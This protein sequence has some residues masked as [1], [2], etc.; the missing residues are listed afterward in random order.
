MIYFTITLS[1][2]FI[3]LVTAGDPIVEISQG[4]LVGKAV[5]F[6]HKDVD[7][8]RTVHVFK[9]IPYAEPPIGDL[10]FRP[11]K[12]KAAWDGVYDATYFRSIC[13]Q[14]A[15]PLFPVNGQQD[16]DCLFL[17]VYAPQLTSAKLP[18]MLFL[19]GGVFIVG[20]GTY[21]YE[22]TAL[23]AIGDVIVVCINYRLGPFGFFTTGDDNAAGNYAFYD[24]IAALQWVQENIEAFGG[25]PSKVT[26]LGESAGSI[27]SEYLMMSP[28]TEGLFQRIIMQSATSTFVGFHG[29]AG[30][31]HHKM[32]HGLGKLLGCDRETSEELVQCL[33]TVPAEDFR[34]AT[35]PTLGLLAQFIGYGTPFPPVVDGTLVTV[36]PVDFIR[37]KMLKKRNLDIMI[38]S[39]AD[40]G[41]VYL[42][43]VRPSALNESTVSMNRSVYE[44]AYPM[45]LPGPLRNNPAVLDAVKLM[46]VNWEEADNDE[47]DYLDAFFQMGTDHGFTCPADVSARS[48]SQ[49]GANVYLYIMTHVPARSIWRLKWMRAAHAEDLPLLFGWH[50]SFWEDWTMPP[51]DVEMSLKVMKYWTNFAK[52]GNPNQ[53]CDDAEVSEEDK[54]EAWPLFKVP[55]LAYKELSLEMNTKYGLKARECAMWN[56]FIPKLLK[57]TDTNIVCS[58]RD[59]ETKKYTEEGNRP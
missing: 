37:E 56:D 23:A 12:A 3:A 9:G 59:D 16:E 28:L 4:K 35:D 38:G 22:G 19:H 55:G 11:T 46:Y 26:L 8:R 20:S 10:R 50:F 58:A 29:K 30:D 27:S 43:T 47:A 25:D 49:A 21:H 45:F 42:L 5:E 48:Y 2:A 51:E 14:P 18:V 15:H 54:P 1:L 39:T 24:Q 13:I 7:V 41:S 33:R 32:A 40:E 53:C 17:N 6:S 44:T 57:H 34:N 36:D 31:F 52:T